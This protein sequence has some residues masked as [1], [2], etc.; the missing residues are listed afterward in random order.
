MPKKAGDLGYFARTGEQ[1]GAEKGDKIAATAAMV[2]VLTAPLEQEHSAT[3]ATATAQSTRSAFRTRHFIDRSRRILSAGHRIGAVV[4]VIVAVAPAAAG[5]A[6]AQSHAHAVSRSSPLAAGIGYTTQTIESSHGLPDLY[7]IDAHYPVMHGLA[8]ASVQQ[9][10]NKELSAPVEQDVSSFATSQAHEAQYLRGFTE[11]DPA[12][13]TV[14]FTAYQTGR[15]ISAKYTSYEHLS[16]GSGAGYGLRS[17]TITL[18]TG[19]SLTNIHNFLTPDALTVSGLTTLAGDLQAQRGISKCDSG[20][21]SSDLVLHVLEQSIST[22]G[23][24]LNVTA[25]GI[26]FS[27]EEGSMSGRACQPIGTLPLSAMAGLVSPALAGLVGPPSLA[28]S[29]TP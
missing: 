1:I 21:G 25:G 3:T 27:F 26:E 24:V 7:K 10:I 16:G 18:E 22:G 11:T 20:F 9:K 5:C 28:S 17:L 12:T 6:T 29:A 15:L 4:A 8:D 2:V 14:D 13:L 23:V 19:E